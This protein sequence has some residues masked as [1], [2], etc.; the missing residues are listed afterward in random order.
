MRNPKEE[1]KAS[2]QCTTNQKGRHG[3]PKPEII[4]HRGMV[5]EAPE[6]TLAGFARAAAFNS[7]AIEFDLQLSKDGRLVVCH[8]HKV[9]RTTSGKGWVRDFTLAE[10]KALD[11]GSW[12]SPEFAGQTIPTVEEVLTLLG[13]AGW[14]GKIYFELKTLR[15]DYPG[16]EA[17]LARVI[18]DFGLA[19]RCAVNSFNHHSLVRM[20]AA[21]PGIPTTCV[22][23]SHMVRPWEYARSIGCTGYAPHYTAIDQELVDGCHRAGISVIAWTVDDRKEIERLV[24]LGVDG[25]ITNRPDVMRSCLARGEVTA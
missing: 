6:H 19:G 13:D 15:Y 10:L 23:G 9:D 5:H 14:A 22:D 17:A 3:V 18:Q 11:A 25:I 16:I 1:S 20:Q 7:D 12:F 21:L 24:A 8:D 4:A 2:E